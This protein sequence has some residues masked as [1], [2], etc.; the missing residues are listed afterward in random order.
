LYHAYQQGEYSKSIFLTRWNNQS[1][2]SS[3]EWRKNQPGE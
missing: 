3:D 1:D 2:H